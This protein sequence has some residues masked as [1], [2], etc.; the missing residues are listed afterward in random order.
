MS[1]GLIA[2]VAS[3]LYSKNRIHLQRD[4]HAD[5]T[6]FFASYVIKGIL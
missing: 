5:E 1:H 2:C 3:K 4:I 6:E